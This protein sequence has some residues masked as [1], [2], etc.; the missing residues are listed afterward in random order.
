VL[1]TFGY[2]HPPAR[3]ILTATGV[4]TAAGSVF[5]VYALNLSAITAAMMAGPDAHPDPSRRWIATV[6][7]GSTYLVLGL[8][9]GAATAL[10]SAS[11]PILIT[12]VAGL[13]LLGALASAITAALED[14]AH[15][16]VAIVTFLVV[17]SGIQLAGVGSAFWGLIA[18][19]AVMLWLAVGRRRT[20][21][22]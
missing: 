17:A 12:A 15:R 3:A 1:R 6:S 16:I 8:G 20:R 19:G 14:A 10:V 5:G 21:T 2:Q 11:P 18:G 22:D 13:A 7:S 4:A 9:A